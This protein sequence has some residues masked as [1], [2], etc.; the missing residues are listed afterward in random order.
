MLEALDLPTLVVFILAFVIIYN[1]MT[2][3]K[4]QPPSPRGLPFVGDILLLKA[5]RGKLPEVFMQ[6]AQ[7]LGDIF[8]LTFGKLHIVVVNG[9]TRIHE[10]LMK[11]ADVFSDRPSFLLIS[12]KIGTGVI[13]S[14]GQQWKALRRM[15]LHAMRDF[16]M[17][18]ISMEDKMQ[19]EVKVIIGVMSENEK[20][21]IALHKYLAMATSNI[22]CNIIFGSRFEYEDEQFQ[23]MLQLLN[24]VFRRPGMF[25]ICNAFPVLRFVP[26]FNKDL[27]DNI[28]AFDRLAQFVSDI[29][30]DHESTYDR[31]N[32]RDFIDMFIK[33][34]DEDT[35][36][37]YTL[38]NFLRVIVDLFMAGTET[39]ST[40]L[41][42]AILYMVAYPDIQDRCQRELEEVIGPGRTVQFQ[43][44]FKLPYVRETFVKATLCEIQRISTIAPLSVPHAT[45]QDTTLGGF[46]IPRESIVLVNLLSVHQDPTLWPDPGTF[47]P[48]RFLEDGKVRR[49]EYFMPFSAGPR[50]CA[51]ETLAKMELF[52][53]FAN[54]L[55]WFTFR[56]VEGATLNLEGVTGLTRSPRPFEVV[57]TKR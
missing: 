8:T 25:Q 29:V 32:I 3:R 39:S 43:D 33:F 51:G 48:C 1:V 22:I 11:R 10:V 21:P 45:L 6:Q 37:S 34:R 19:D 20:K 46:N 42:W 2:R 38:R 31:N 50:V 14:S 57:V 36:A 18:K 52:L 40:T 53:Y 44:R 27:Q 56:K 17:G 9:Y 30:S 5:N 28:E 54:L 49:G 4:N 12:K 41:N 24:D 55:Q 47:N 35:D 7:Q 26:P 15:S 23:N 16:G 13:L